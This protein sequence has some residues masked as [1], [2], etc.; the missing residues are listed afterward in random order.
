[1]VQLLLCNCVLYQ[2]LCAFVGSNASVNNPRSFSMKIANSVPPV[3]FESVYSSVTQT[4]KECSL[5]SFTLFYVQDEEE[6]REAAEASHKVMFSGSIIIIII[7][8]GHY[9]RLL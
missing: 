2:E 5:Q 8:Y 1:M 9:Y 7:A 3:T 6:V 4:L